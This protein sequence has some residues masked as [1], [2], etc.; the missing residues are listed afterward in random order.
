MNVTPHVLVM[1]IGEQAVE[2][3]QL[4]LELDRARRRV[5]EL[6]AQNKIVTAALAAKDQAGAGEDE[7]GPTEPPTE[8]VP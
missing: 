5:E 3:R 4:R 8:S 1:Q 7:Q 6:E 2:I